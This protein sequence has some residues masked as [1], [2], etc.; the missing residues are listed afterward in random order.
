MRQINLNTIN[1]FAWNQYVSELDIQVLVTGFA[2]N[3]LVWPTFMNYK[4]DI[5]Y[6][7]YLPVTGKFR[8]RYQDGETELSPGYAYL[9]PHDLP[10]KYEGIEPCSHYWFHFISDKLQY[11]PAFLEPLSIA[12]DN[13]TRKLFRDLIKSGRMP[14][15]FRQ[16]AAVKCAATTI[17]AMFLDKECENC[18]DI[19]HPV[20][21]F[22]KV[23]DYI[24]F[25]YKDDIVIENLAEMMDMPQYKFTAVFRQY[26]KHPPKKYISGVRIAN[27]KKLLIQSDMLIKEIASHCG[28]LDDLYFRRIFKKYTRM[29]PLQYRLLYRQ[30]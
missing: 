2:R 29:T 3:F 24:R 23:I 26:F 21:F 6:R 22:D 25:H 7:C 30:E 1:K 11:F 17:A 14:P 28:Y 13:S 12:A 18:A 9:F 20:S 16:S 27:A 5:F 15:S 10:L 8:I 4:G 19:K